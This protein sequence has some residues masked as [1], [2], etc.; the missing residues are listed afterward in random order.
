MKLSIAW[1]FDHL[2]ADWRS[3]DVRE[4]VDLFNKKTA[5]IESVS[6]VELSLADLAVAQ[7]LDHDDTSAMLLL[8]EWSQK[9]SVPARPGVKKGAWFLIK[10]N[11]KNF[12]WASGLDCGGVKEILVPEI[13]VTPL[14]AQGSW[15]ERCE[16]HDYLIDVDNKSITHRPDL[17][18]HRG[19]AREFGAL[20]DIPLIPL[21]R[22]IVKKNIIHHEHTAV[23][24]Q[25]KKI[26]LRI[27]APD[28]C[29]RV[30]GLSLSSVA[31]APSDS[32]MALRL[33]RLD[34]KPINAIVDATNY[35]MLDLGHPM[36]AFDEN[37]LTSSMVVVR[38]AKKKES[39]ALLDG[40]SVELTPDDL[41]IADGDRAVSLAGVM[42]G[43][44]TAVTSA[45]HSLFLEAACFDAATIRKTA[46]RYKKRTEASARF[47]KTLDPQQASIAL[48][49]FLA[50]LNELNISYT[51][52]DALLSVG[53]PYESKKIIIEH[54]SI[55]QRL[56][57][58]IDPAF[59]QKRSKN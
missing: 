40:T 59:V 38:R 15:K 2:E 12:A 30:V 55:E 33:L 13:A 17:W 41:V 37:R 3:V 6:R 9:I 48:E 36:H 45:T 47:E 35:V 21:E 14:Q 8:P 43:N 5:E 26:S 56:G 25:G 51:A 18:G 19:I 22:F 16:A 28:L 57:G 39:L 23:D 44:D 58:I 27:D 10:R 54:S 29:S 46:A 50:L 4:L 31:Y 49:R 20:L 1:I 34:Q 32:A 42:G 52:C 11:P 7:V 24:T 53:K